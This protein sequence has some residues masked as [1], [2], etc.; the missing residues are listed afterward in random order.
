MSNCAILP[1]YPLH[2]HQPGNWRETKPIRISPSTAFSKFQPNKSNHLLD[3]TKPASVVKLVWGYRTTNATRR[4][5]IASQRTWRGEDLQALVPASVGAGVIWFLGRDTQAIA[6]GST[7]GD[8]APGSGSG[9]PE[10]MEFSR[11]LVGSSHFTK[12]IGVYGLEGC[13]RQGFL[14]RLKTMNWGQ[15]VGIPTE[16]VLRAEI[17]GFVSRSA[18]WIA[19]NL[20]YFLFLSDS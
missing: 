18:L 3:T 13:V 11:G 7:E 16:F 17:I 10:G 12:E 6:I 15:P 9:P 5:Q 14:T 2:A 20:S 19:S 4:N 8:S 1:A